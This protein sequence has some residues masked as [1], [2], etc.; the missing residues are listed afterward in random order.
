MRATWA[1]RNVTTGTLGCI[2]G[3]PAANRCSP[4]TAGWAR[5]P[6]GPLVATWQACRGTL[7]ALLRPDVAPLKLLDGGAGGLREPEPNHDSDDSDTFFVVSWCE[8]I[9]LLPW[10]PFAMTETNRQ[11]D[12]KLNVVFGV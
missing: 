2:A 10:N 7:L 1:P 6:R 9:H 5:D 11:T 3:V 12:E 8:W 4:G